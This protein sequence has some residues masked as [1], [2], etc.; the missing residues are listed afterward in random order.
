M[1]LLGRSAVALEWLEGMIGDPQAKALA[2]LRAVR[3]LKMCLFL[4]ITL[5][6]S[7]QASPDL[8]KGI[9]EIL[10]RHRQRSLGRG[11]CGHI[12]VSGG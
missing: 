3:V 10:R 1:D 11:G 6:E 9:I 8:R 12:Y 2:K 7:Q 4:L 5:A